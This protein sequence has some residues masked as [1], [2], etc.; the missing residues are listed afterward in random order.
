MSQDPPRRSVGKKTVRLIARFW[1][2]SSLCCRAA[3]YY[4]RIF[5]ARRG[6]TQGGPLSPTIFNLMVD[7]VVREWE[8]QLVARGLGLDDVR[9]LFACFYADDGLLA[10]R[11]PEHLQLAFDLLT[12]LFDRVGLKTNTTKLGAWVE[13]LAN[14]LPPWAAYRVTKN[15]RLVALDKRPGVRPVRQGRLWKQEALRGAGSGD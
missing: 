13:W 11:D 3:G 4:G 9:R 6:V 2:Q 14:E 1:K 8:R 5:H 7:A 12:D 15:C 10:A